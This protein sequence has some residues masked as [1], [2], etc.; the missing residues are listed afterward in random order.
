[1]LCTDEAL[2]GRCGPLRLCSTQLH[3]STK[4]QILDARGARVAFRTCEERCR[5]PLL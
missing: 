5:T 1:M 4:L 3:Q 2:L